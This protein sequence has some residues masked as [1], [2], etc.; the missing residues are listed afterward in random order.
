MP[1]KVYVIVFALFAI[2]S[3]CQ[4]SD[5]PAPS[6]P[7]APVS[8][9]P[10]NATNPAAPGSVESSAP[11]VKAKVDV[12]QLLTAD[13]LKTVQGEPFKEAQRSDRQDGGF[14]VAQCYYT[15][16]TGSNSVVLNVTT[17]SESGGTAS[18]RKFWEDTFGKE[19]REARN[20]STHEREREREKRAEKQKTGERAEEGEEEEGAP[21]QKVNGI[22]E[23]AFWIASRVGGAL[24]VLKKDIFFRISVGGAADEKSKLKKSKTLA[25]Q[26]L[27][28][29]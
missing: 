20:K 23:E 6:Q 21:P 25:Q 22:G 4:S 7:G 28:R 1:S 29:V 2:M 17:A 19:E 14:I 8:A 3:G 18:P 9:T 24:Y 15:L 10:A 16:P 26:V 11:A 13:D 5:S 12:C 27:K